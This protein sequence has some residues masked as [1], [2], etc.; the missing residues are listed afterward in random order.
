VSSPLNRKLDEK[1][2]VMS[3]W[4]AEKRSKLPLDYRETSTSILGEINLSILAQ[5]I[6]ERIA[7][8]KSF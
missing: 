5:E 7:P 6:S 3:P 4:Q 1:L 8:K 2:A